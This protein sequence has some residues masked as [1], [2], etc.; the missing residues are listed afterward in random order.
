MACGPLGQTLW[1]TAFQCQAFRCAQALRWN[2]ITSFAAV[3]YQSLRQHRY[4]GVGKHGFYRPGSINELR[5]ICFHPSHLFSP[6]FSCV[7]DDS[8]T[9]F[10]APNQSTVLDTFFVLRVPPTNN[11]AERTLRP[12]VIMRKICF[13]NRSHDGGQ[14]LAKIMSV[15]ATARRHGHNPLRVFYRLFTQPPDK[16]MRFI[17]KKTS[18]KKSQ[19]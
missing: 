2:T 5:P 13:G 11:L 17:Y 19:A 10:T 7:F 3:E 1:T 8:N 9:V 18:A 4:G 16:V 15:K 12:L 6:A 14:R